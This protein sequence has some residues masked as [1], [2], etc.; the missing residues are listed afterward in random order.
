MPKRA[1]KDGMSMTEANAPVEE[2]IR[3]A[4][5]AYLYSNG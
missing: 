4:A 5:E 3:L 1:W 2:Q